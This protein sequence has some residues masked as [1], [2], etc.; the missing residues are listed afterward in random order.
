MGQGSKWASVIYPLK[1]SKWAAVVYIL[2]ESKNGLL[3]FTSWKCQTNSEQQFRNKQQC[4]NGPRVK[5]GFCYLPPERVKMGQGFFGWNRL[6]KQQSQIGPK[7]VKLGLAHFDSESN[8]V[9]ESR[10]VG[11][12]A[13]QLVM[14]IIS[15]E[16]PHPILDGDPPC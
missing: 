3:L 11:T 4:Q 16:F 2:K 10:W 7:L 14:D 13:L 9:K 1:E 6:L 12:Y 15:E 8:W 5:M